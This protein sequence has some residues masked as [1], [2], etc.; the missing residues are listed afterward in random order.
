MPSPGPS[1]RSR[2]WRSRRLRRAR[3]ERVSFPRSFS[4]PFSTKR[5]ARP[6]A[7]SSSSS[8]TS[9]LASWP[10][11]KE[12]SSPTTRELG[13]A[14]LADSQRRRLHD[15]AAAYFESRLPVRP[16]FISAAATHALKGADA[17]RGIRL[18]LAAA[19]Q[20]ERLFAYDPAATFYEGVLE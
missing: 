1:L 16:D 18:G 15:V 3:S 14:A 19:A 5:R 9:S 8:T 6:A 2:N 10:Y 13:A 7:S 17:E 20:A 4:R 11:R 12:S